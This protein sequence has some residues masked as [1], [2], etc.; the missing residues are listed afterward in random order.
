MKQIGIALMVAGIAMVSWF[1]YQYWS[2]TQSV[3]KLD[4]DVVKD[5]AETEDSSTSDDFTLEDGGKSEDESHSNVDYEDGDDIAQLVM[6]S[7][8]LS[9]EVFWGTGED[10]LSKGVGM[11]DSEFT[12][13]P[14]AGGHTVLSGHR[15]SVFAPVGDLEDGDS[16]YVNYKDEDY[17]YKIKKTWITDAAD[18]S[19]IVEKDD[20]T[21]TLTT[22]YPFQFI[23]SAPD[24]YIVEAEFVQKGNLLNLD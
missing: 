10:A 12:K 2:S 21:L 13:P 15:D 5:S 11:Y 18:R 20:P 4:S 3:T 14:G 22:C 16:I 7:I 6:P 9:F 23:G 8:D 19:V 1:G 17:E 24:R